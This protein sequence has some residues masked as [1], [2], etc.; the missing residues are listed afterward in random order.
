M[1]VNYEKN[2]T[3]IMVRG[4]AQACEEAGIRGLAAGAVDLADRLEHH[5]AELIGHL[6]DPRKPAIPAALKEH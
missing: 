5:R 4:R 6:N 3:L 2:E 1:F